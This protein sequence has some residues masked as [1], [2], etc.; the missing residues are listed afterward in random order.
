MLCTWNI[1]PVSKPSKRIVDTHT[2]TLIMYTIW[3]GNCLL[4]EPMC[5][6]KEQQESYEWIHSSK[7]KRAR[8]TIEPKKL[9]YTNFSYGLSP[10]CH[11]FSFIIQFSFLV[12]YYLRPVCQP[13]I[14]EKSKR[15]MLYSI[16]ACIWLVFQCDEIV[17]A[18]F[19][20]YLI[21]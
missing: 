12:L 5:N 2:Q 11:S 6:G 1:S 18:Y 16:A 10:L 21:N 19:C 7:K 8:F 13:K 17:V 15:A 3:C 14:Y 4:F 9:L 20:K